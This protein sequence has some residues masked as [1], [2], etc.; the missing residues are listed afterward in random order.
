VTRRGALEREGRAWRRASGAARGRRSRAR[1]REG[2]RSVR[3]DVPIVEI[4]EALV[5]ANRL[6]AWDAAN[7]EAVAMALRELAA[8]WLEKITRY[9]FDPLACEMISAE[10]ETETHA[11][12]HIPP[13]D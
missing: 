5:D 8:D 10:S 2:L 11:Q 9:G 1:K 6:P 7:V 13:G 3:L 12:P 4:S